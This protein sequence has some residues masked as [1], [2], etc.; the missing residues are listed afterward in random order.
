MRSSSY[1]V[2]EVEYVGF[3]ENF[4]LAINK[5]NDTLHYWVINKTQKSMQI[6]DQN[7]SENTITDETKLS[8]VSESID[9]TNYISLK[10]KLN[11]KSYSK[12][13]CR[14]QLNYK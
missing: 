12:D 11:I 5:V 3:D 10:E 14:K 1:I 2:R 9:S 8:N 7:Q 13:Y 4:I 6:D